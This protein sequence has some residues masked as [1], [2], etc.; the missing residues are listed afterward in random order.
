MCGIAGIFA[1]KDSADAVVRT[2]LLAIRDHMAARG[3]DGMGEWEATDHRITLAHRR[4]SIIDLS[5][6]AA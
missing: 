2:E 3:P 5:P 1:Y 6:A 4:L